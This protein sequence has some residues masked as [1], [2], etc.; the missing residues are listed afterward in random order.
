MSCHYH[1]SYDNELND[2]DLS[3]SQRQTPDT[4]LTE[5]DGGNVPKS[6]S[7]PFLWNCQFCRQECSHFPMNTSRHSI[8][9]GCTFLTTFGT[10]FC[11]GQFWGAKFQPLGLV[12]AFPSGRTGVAKKAAH[13]QQRLAPPATNHQITIT[14]RHLLDSMLTFPIILI[15]RINRHSRN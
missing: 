6:E 1:H 12:G 2:F 8:S 15:N 14:L 13:V 4:I 9:G 3:Q 10:N 11:Q 5:L 7:D